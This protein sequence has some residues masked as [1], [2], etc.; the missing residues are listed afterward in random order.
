MY[1]VW[2][3]ILFQII[4][5]MAHFWDNKALPTPTVTLP[6]TFLFFQ[7]FIIFLIFIEI[8][9][10]SEVIWDLKREGKKKLKRRDRTRVESQI[11]CCTH[12]RH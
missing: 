7:L 6:V 11:D 12:L 1:W 5:W 8:K 4:K 10:F 3:I 2:I 9:C